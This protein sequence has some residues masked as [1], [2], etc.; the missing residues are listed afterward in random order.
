MTG[1]DFELARKV[2]ALA[3]K[4]KDS[5]PHWICTPSGEY[6]TNNGNDWCADCGRFMFRH[7]RRKDRKNARDYFFDG[8]WRTESDTHRF[9]AHCGCWL[10]VSL[11]DCGVK[12][13]LEHYRENGV[14]SD[15][16][17]AYAIDLLMSAASWGC[18]HEQEIMDLA[19]QL[20][21]NHERQESS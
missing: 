20:I 2:E 21:E 9:C 6:E 17:D 3:Q 4:V 11:T 19:R 1:F 8:G 10:R 7:L 12:E 16:N 5:N 13:E 18:E 14:G 15:V